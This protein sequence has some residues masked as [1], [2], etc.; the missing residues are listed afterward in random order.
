MK[1]FGREPALWLALFAGL[2]QV[3]STFIW[4][5]TPGEQSVL[6]GAAVAAAGLITAVMVH[7]GIKAAVLGFVQATLALATGFGLHLDPTQQSV[8]MS[9]VAALL[10]MWVWGRVTAPVGPNG[11]PAQ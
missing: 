10:A 5:L 4:T 7:D 3:V 2:V 1:I 9:A 11:G 8:I 6:N